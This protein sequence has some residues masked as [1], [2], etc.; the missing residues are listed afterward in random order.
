MEEKIYIP[1]KII[2][3]LN[4]IKKVKLQLSYTAIQEKEH[5]LEEME[6]PLRHIFKFPFVH[7]INKKI[8]KIK[9]LQWFIEYNN[10]LK[11]LIRF[12]SVNEN[13]NDYFFPSPEKWM[14]V[15]NNL[16]TKEEKIKIL[17]SFSKINKV[18]KF[19]KIGNKN[20]IYYTV[21]FDTGYVDLM[22]KSIE[23]I[24][25]NSK[26]NFEFLIIT[27]HQTKKIIDN[28]SFSKDAKIDFLITKTPE[29]GWEASENKTKIFQYSKINNYKKILFLDC[30]IICVSDVSKIFDIN[31]KNN[32][33]YTARNEN[34]T[35]QDHL[36]I[37]HGFDFFNLSDIEEIKKNNQMPFNSGQFLF[38]NSI[39]MKMH[40]QNIK[41]LLKN[42]SGEYFFEQCFM[43]YYFC[44]NNLTNSFDLNEK[45]LVSDILGD[46]TKKQNKCLIHLIKPVLDAKAKI[47]LINNFCF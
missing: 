10:S 35:F 32:T 1:K 29:D 15:K 13:Q 43:N 9:T 22:Q 21:Y 30:D 17:N 45:V 2:K 40:F 18:N 11:E 7:L 39:E 25:H 41:N 33:L 23:S 37:Y 26:I 31:I 14:K 8:N 42:W 16:S 27:D 3:N 6:L 5:M 44:K 34:L 28:L 47:N 4:K 20:L 46:L 19:V 36:T 24:L 38:E 12:A